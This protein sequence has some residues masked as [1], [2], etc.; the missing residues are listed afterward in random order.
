MDNLKTIEFEQWMKKDVIKLF[1]EEYNLNFDNYNKK[2]ERLYEDEFQKDKCIRVVAIVDKKIIGFQSY[3]Y[4]PYKSDNKN[5]N[6]YQSG[7]SIVS[8]KFRGKGIFGLLLKK[9]EEIIMKRN[10]DFLIGFPVKESIGSF[11]RKNWSN[12][13]NLKWYVKLISLNP[14]TFRKSKNL[15]LN[16]TKSYFDLKNDGLFTINNSTS[17][18]LYRSQINN[19]SLYHVYK[20]KEFIVEFCCKLTI[21]NKIISELIIGNIQFNKFNEEI[22]NKAF[23]NLIKKIIASKSVNIISFAISEN[24]EIFKLILQYNNFKLLKKKIF[25]IFKNYKN[26]D[27]KDI[28]IFRADIDT[29]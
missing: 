11:K 12:N 26:I 5:Y 29:W 18:E 22:I 2:F 9:I 21:R 1:I 16:K 27:L 6:S 3:F 4:W 15:S 24:I 25:F 14:L 10:I 17:F 13:F 20:E 8:K 23:K 7:N 19:E 28:L